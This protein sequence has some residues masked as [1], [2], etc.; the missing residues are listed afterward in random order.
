MT[1]KAE[2][3]IVVDD[4]FTVREAISDVL[5]SRSLRPSPSSLQPN[6]FG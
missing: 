2:L 6:A 4:D 3:G 5:A 1:Q